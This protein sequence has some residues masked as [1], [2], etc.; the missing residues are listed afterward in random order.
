MVRV[1]YQSGKTICSGASVMKIRGRRKNK[2][3]S[4]ECYRNC[5]VGDGVVFKSCG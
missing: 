2:R 3:A 4:S 1:G 5:D